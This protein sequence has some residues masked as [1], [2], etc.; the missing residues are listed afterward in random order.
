MVQDCILKGLK[1][2][3]L[4]HFSIELDV[5]IKA[6]RE[7][8]KKKVKKYSLAVADK[9]AAFSQLSSMIQKKDESAKK[10]PSSTKDQGHKE[11]ELCFDNKDMGMKEPLLK[12]PQSQS[13][14]KEKLE[15]IIEDKNKKLGYSILNEEKKD[16]LLLDLEVTLT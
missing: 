3:V 10:E 13:P 7:R 15:N 11:I 4:G 6:S 2:P 12:S 9:N 5:F 8:I 16:N 1:Q 14:N